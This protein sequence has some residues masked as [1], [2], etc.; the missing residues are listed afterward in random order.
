MNEL[1]TELKYYLNA[2]KSE[3]INVKKLST[4]E[5]ISNWSICMMIRRVIDLIDVGEWDRIIYNHRLSTLR[6]YQ[7]K[8]MI[9]L[10]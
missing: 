5:Q 3:G 9:K 7:Q 2:M 10:N 6:E 8:R 1:Q 4:E